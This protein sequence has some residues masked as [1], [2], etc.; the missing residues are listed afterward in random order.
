M[1]KD[2]QTRDDRQPMVIQD[3]RLVPAYYQEDEISLVDLWLILARRK[4]LMLF[5]LSIFVIGGA[6]TA[7]LSPRTYTYSTPVEIARNGDALL[8]APETAL[9]KLQQSY[10]PAVLTENSRQDGSEAEIQ[11]SIPKNSALIVLQ[12]EGRREDEAQVRR[13]HEKVVALL[14]ADHNR[15]LQQLRDSLDAQLQNRQSELAALEDEARQLG[16]NEKN[17][18]E[19]EQ[20]L[21]QRLAAV[22]KTM[23]TLRLDR[24]DLVS[25]GD[26]S[27]D[28]L[29]TLLMDN[30]LQQFQKEEAMLLE[31]LHT[32][33]AG[34]RETL[35]QALA[36]NRLQ[37]AAQRDKLAAIR[38]RLA[39]LQATR[40]INPATRS[41]EPTGGGRKIILALAIVLGGLLAVFAAFFGEFL[42]KVRQKQ[43]QDSEGA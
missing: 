10:I 28:N 25:E 40:A 3:P 8:D 11:A 21:T 37:Q 7:W 34:E 36:E 30:T 9:A 29:L 1:T 24:H 14:A 13:L 26:S 17:L 22:R 38:A 31:Q 23:E 20:A 12:S 16:T 39:G 27:A 32:G 6:V 5:I 41:L 19:K 35:R 43:A 42:E 33:L 15:V 18:D 2:K 4:R